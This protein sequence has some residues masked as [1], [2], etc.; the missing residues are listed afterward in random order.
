MLKLYTTSQHKLLGRLLLVLITA[1]SPMAISQFAMAAPQEADAEETITT[2]SKAA[3]VDSA[4][5]LGLLEST[6]D[7]PSS[8]TGIKELNVPPK[9]MI[10]LYEKDRPEW[11][12]KA[13]TIADGKL[14]LYV[15]GELCATEEECQ[16]KQAAAM[17]AEVCK[18]FDTEVFH[19]SDASARTPLTEEFIASRWVDAKE[20]YLAKVQTSDGTM[21]QLWSI[22]RIDDE[23]I[24]TMKQWHLSSVQPVRIRTLG[25][26]LLGVLSGIGLIHLGARFTSGRSRKKA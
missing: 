3:E 8:T 5:E 24:K 22:V 4:S 10:P 18:Y 23:G 17:Y 20:N 25:L 15:G 14:V 6:A 21:Y 26:G 16:K 2:E 11:L 19:E 12:F 13:P 7:S 1:S 9:N